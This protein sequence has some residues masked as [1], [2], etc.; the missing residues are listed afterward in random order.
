M[1]LRWFQGWRDRVEIRWIIITKPYTVMLIRDEYG[2]VADCLGKWR[3]KWTD[4]G[5]AGL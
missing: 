1:I 3:E 5:L 2:I 4:C